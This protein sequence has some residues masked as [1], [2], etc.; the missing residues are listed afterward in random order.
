M[1]KYIVLLVLFS[2]FLTGCSA[3]KPPVGD[4]DTEIADME[5]LAA[6]EEELDRMT[7]PEQLKPKIL[8]EV[9]E[10]MEEMEGTYW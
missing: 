8:S 5:M 3:P 6:S 2:S 10:A 1:V 7:Q 4:Y 9:E